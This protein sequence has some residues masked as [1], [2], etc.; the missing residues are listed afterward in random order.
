MRFMTTSLSKPV[1]NITER[2]LK[3][4]CQDCR[5]FFEYESVKDKLVKYNCL[6]CNKDYSNKF[7]EGLNKKC[8]NIFKFSNN[9]INKSV[10]LLRK[11]VYPH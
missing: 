11:C 6:S 4:K 7:E 2:I 5:C 10:L 3:S 8:R 1:D 9:E